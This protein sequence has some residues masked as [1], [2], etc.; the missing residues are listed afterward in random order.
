M[1]AKP[2]PTLLA[3]AVLAALG[4]LLTLLGAAAWSAPLAYLESP[5]PQAYFRSGIGLIR[6]WSCEPGPVEISVDGGPL[7]ATGSGTERPDTA[8]VCGR[9]NTGFGLI[10]NWNRLSQGVHNL[11]ALVGGV[12]FANVNFTVATLGGEFVTGLTGSYTVPDFPAPGASAKIA[13]SQPHQNFM[14][15]RQTEAPPVPNPPSSTQARLES[16]EQGS[17]E[18]GVGLIR[19]WVCSAGRV[20]VSI[21]GGPL[22][23]T[24]HG[25]DRPDTAQ[26]CGRTNTGFGLT[27]NW[28][29]T[30]DGVH[31][32]RAFADGVEF[33]NVNFTVTTLGAS[34]ITGVLEKIRLLGFPGGGAAANLQAAAGDQAATT[35][36]WSEPDQNFVIADSTA[37][38]TKI[39]IV[40]AVTDLLNKFAVLGVGSNSSDAVGVHASKNAQGQASDISGVTWADTSTQAWADLRLGADGLPDAYQDSS[41]TQAHIS[42]IT[43]NS[44]T[45]QFLN[46]SGQAQGN[47]VTTPL[48]GAFLQILQQAVGRIRQAAGLT[49]T[50]AAQFSSATE[51]RAE[52]AASIADTIRFSLNSLL[53]RLFGSG[54]VAS[55]E[56]LCAIRTAASTAGIAAPVAATGCQSPMIA[57]LL[58]LANSPVTQA[59]TTDASPDLRVE[60]ALL[61]VQ[62]V[63]LAPCA[64]PGDSAGCLFPAS[65]ALR[66]IAAPPAKQIPPDDSPPGNISVPDV[67]GLN[68][69]A[70]ATAISNAGL[71]VGNIRDQASSTV[72]AGIVISQDPAAGALVSRGATVNLIRSAGPAL[73]TVPNV[74]GQSQGTASNTLQNVGLTVGNVIQ[75]TSSTVPAGNV[76]SQNPAAGA[77]VAPN[78]AVALVVSS[79]P[80]PVTVPNVVGQ[81]QSAAASALQN[82]GLTVGAVSEQSSATVPQGQIISQNPAAG[83]AVAPGS[84]VNLVVSSG[85]ESV[86]VPN[87]VG[88]SQSAATGRL[89]STG[90]T[91]GSVTQESSTSV[92]Q[93][94]VIRQNPAAGA[95]VAPGSAVDLVVSSGP[96]PVTVPNVVGQSQ[97]AA[98]A[99]LQTVGLTVGNIAQQPSSTVPAGSVISQNPAAGA[100]VASGSAVALAVSSGPAPVT[101][102]N[103]VGQSQSVA[104][105]TLQSAGLTAGSITTE[106]S[107]A[108]PAGIV[109]RQNP[110]AGAAVAPGSA[111][112]LVVSS[113]PP[114]VTVPDVVGLTLQNAQNVIARAGL[115]TGSMT[116]QTTGNFSLNNLIA[117]QNPAAGASVVRGASV[118]LVIWRYRLIVN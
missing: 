80:A 10:Y 41:G 1:K 12:E 23:A 81:T 21:D 44:V 50:S 39:A 101:V 61:L 13:W 112:A 70:A 20:E 24:A 58:A 92:P 17:S 54:S 79:G 49:A 18:S 7:Q 42:Q 28:N 114:P 22:L 51:T 98:S 34:F 29:S 104:G 94:T 72:A 14:F 83:A 59:A 86:T 48:N 4:G 33:A 57:N 68:S 35:V 53:V 76:I 19:G 25:T 8:A 38:G 117:S 66:Q 103:V 84:A 5:S 87:V 110:A 88:Q 45:V 46:P 107:T 116:D 6:G 67:V 75:Q 115:L 89:E 85:A 11:R 60:P 113:G 96:A 30:G 118:N 73:V 47:P 43:S 99:T 69:S 93:G 9:T 74:V 62:D 26:A 97:S 31:N 32:L 37:T 91:V 90:L 64:A 40:S 95:A 36:Q 15:T 3:P 52:A 100:S 65:A 63:L 78:S 105:S 16:P 106:S 71:T 111:V 56:M 2:A 27:H 109:I 82:A 55:G 77:S 108:A 102:P